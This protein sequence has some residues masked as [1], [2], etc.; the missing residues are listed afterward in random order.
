MNSLFT[1]LESASE[2]SPALVLLVL[3][4]ATVTSEDLACVTAGVLVAKG[5][6]G[7]ALAV[8]GCL[9]GIMISDVGLFLMGKWW[10]ERIIKI[11]PISWFVTPKRLDLGKSLYQRYGGALVLSSRFL[12]GTRMLAYIAAGM[13]GYPWKRFIVYMGLACAVWTPLLV[14]FAT[15]FGGTILTWLEAY[16]R[17]ALLAFPIAILVVWLLLK[18]FFYLAESL[19][20]RKR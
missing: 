8:S 1:W 18:G 5:T 3:A 12:P 20:K 11:P 16:E 19:Q 6:F 13:L 15:T 7:F 4:V 17:W 9:L 10:G 14:G 2:S